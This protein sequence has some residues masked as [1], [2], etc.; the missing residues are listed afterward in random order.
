MA[1]RWKTSP[2][3]L[4]W[5]FHLRDAVWSDG[6]PLTSDDFLFASRRLLDPK[7]A[8]SYA[9]FP[10]IIKNAQKISAGHLPGA[11]LGVT[12]PDPRALEIQL[13]QPAPYLLKC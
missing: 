6:T 1:K 10:N 8:A 7:L 11:A 12:T 3:G 2:D 9:Y 13:E 4:T 5:T